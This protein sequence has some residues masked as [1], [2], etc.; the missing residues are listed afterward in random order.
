[1]QRGCPRRLW[2][3]TT[4]LGSGDGAAP[5]LAHRPLFVDHEHERVVHLDLGGAQFPGLGAG[6]QVIVLVVPNLFHDG[7]TVAVLDVM[8]P[9]V[10]LLLGVDHVAVDLV[11]RERHV[12]VVEELV[13]K[14]D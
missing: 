3:G 6:E 5:S 14:R 8:L 7:V 2:N 1:M 12:I 13:D 10:N 4:W 11:H 9:P